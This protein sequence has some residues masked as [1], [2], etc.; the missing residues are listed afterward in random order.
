[1][2]NVV[3]VPHVA[4]TELEH[5]HEITEDDLVRCDRPMHVAHAHLVLLRFVPGED[6]HLLRNALLARQYAPHELLPHRSRPAGDENALVLQDHR[7]PIAASSV[8]IASHD[9][10]V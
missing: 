9:G 5:A 3:V 1:G 6:D 7:R 8:T 4:D 2:A 10:G